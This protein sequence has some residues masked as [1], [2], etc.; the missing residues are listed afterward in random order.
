MPEEIARL[1]PE[2]I[3]MSDVVYY[4]EVKLDI[5]YSNTIVCL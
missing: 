2:I 1:Q 3:L 5:H 4:E